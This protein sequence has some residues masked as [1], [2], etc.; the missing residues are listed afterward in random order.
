MTLAELGETL[1][2]EDV[3]EWVAFHLLE[4]ED[5]AKAY[6][7]AKAGAAN[8][9]PSGEPTWERDSFGGR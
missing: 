4:A 2:S 3:E 1:S 6:E 9:K 8:V 7:Q 5:E